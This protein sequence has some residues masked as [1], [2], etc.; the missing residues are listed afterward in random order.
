MLS[1]TMVAVWAVAE[2]EL[3]RIADQNKLPWNINLGTWNVRT[4]HNNES[5]PEL[6]HELSKVRWDVIKISEARRRREN[7]IQ[8]KSIL[9]KSRQS[10]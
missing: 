2:Q 7:K 5:I 4:L 1:E 8:L 3:R 9:E 10:K 6:E